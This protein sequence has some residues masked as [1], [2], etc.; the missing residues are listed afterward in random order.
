MLL[1]SQRS[2]NLRQG[3]RPR[4]MEDLES[5]DPVESDSGKDDGRSADEEDDEKQ[6]T[7]N[8]RS[9]PE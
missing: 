4:Y 5:D 9:I 8:A 6:A 3:K 2:A 1:Q 7:K